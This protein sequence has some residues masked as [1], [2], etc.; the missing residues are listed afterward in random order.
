MIAALPGSQQG[1][2]V[3]VTVS[4][5][6]WMRAIVDGEVVFE[7]RVIPGNA[8]PYE[9]SESVEILT[10][11]GAGLQIFFN[12]QDLGP[13]GQFGEVVDRIY[14]IGGVLTPTPTITSTPTETPRTT[15]TPPTTPTPAP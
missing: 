5:R 11:N 6:A 9:G 4:Q 14:T 13:M 10:G 7:G 12:Q 2:Q 3:Y 8:Y 15:P 1:V